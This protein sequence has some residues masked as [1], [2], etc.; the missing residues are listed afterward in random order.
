MCSSLFSSPTTIRTKDLYI[1]IYRDGT[2]D[3]DLN[4]MEMNISS[5]NILN[6]LDLPNEILLMIIKYLNMVDVIYSLVDVT[7]RLNQLVLNPF[8]TRILDMTCVKM[9]LLPERVYSTDDHVR[10]RICQN[11]LSR[12][13]HQVDELIINQPSIKRVLHTIDFPQLHS[14]LLIDLNETSFFEFL[15]GNSHLVC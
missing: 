7:E 10:E 2:Y 1:Y 15:K 5:R 8:Y 3:I 13:N 14:L 9:E 12:I 4:E 6:L 11:V